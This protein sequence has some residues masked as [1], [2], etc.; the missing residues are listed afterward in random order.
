M[1]LIKNYDDLFEDEKLNSGYVTYLSAI[2]MMNTMSK[3]DKINNK[4]VKDLGLNYS[5]KALVFYE[6]AQAQ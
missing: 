2:H 6:S 1:S 4:I 3:R 5:N